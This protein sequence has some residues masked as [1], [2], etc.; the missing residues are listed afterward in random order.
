MDAHQDD[1]PGRSPKNPGAPVVHLF[2]GPYVTV[3]MQR[4]EVPEGSKHLLAFV[5]LRRRRVDRR[6]AAGTLW[7][8]GNEERAAGNL[9][10]ALWRLG[11]AGINVLVADKRSLGLCSHV[12]VDL[13]MMDQWATRLI[14]GTATAHDLA[15]SPSVFDALDLLPGWYDDWALM[16]RERIRQRL[17]HALEALSG[18]LVSLSRFGEAIDAALLAVSVDPLRE[19]AQRAL[20]EAHVAEGNLT[21]ARRSYVSYRDLIRRE[22]S[23]EPSGDLSALLRVGRNRTVNGESWAAAGPQPGSTKSL[24]ATAPRNTGS[25]TRHHVQNDFFPAQSG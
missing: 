13:H 21:E 23:V 8:F 11:R 22:L 12:I 7:P 1:L 5:A 4:R 15:I 25:V 2:A 19:S 16:E 3:G 24:E 10:S 20:I 17:L 9:R 18:C 14:Q 6:H